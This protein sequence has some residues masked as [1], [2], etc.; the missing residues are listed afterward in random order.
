V[1]F[2][3]PPNNAITARTVW[4]LADLVELIRHDLD[5]NVVVFDS[6]NPAFFLID[7]N[8]QEPRPIARPP[9]TMAEVRAWREMLARL[10]GAPAVS[11]AAI[12]GRVGGAGSEFVLACDLRF[13]SLEKAL[14]GQ[15]D[16]RSGPVLDSGPIARLCRLAGRGRALELLL[17][18]GELDG[19]RAEQYGYI[20]RLVADDGLDDEIDRIASRLAHL[21]HDAVAR[22][23]AGLG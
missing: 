14:I 19:R 13:G 9:L 6:A 20:N 8:G 4:E 3:H 17:A 10:S 15:F 18:G 11:I 12:R 21:D 2:D 23:K 22:T 1:T 5:L 7:D 16:V